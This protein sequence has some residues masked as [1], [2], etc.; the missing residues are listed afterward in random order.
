MQRRICFII[1]SVSKLSYHQTRNCT[2]LAA[3]WQYHSKKHLPLPGA[4]ALRANHISLR[5]KRISPNVSSI[6]AALIPGFDPDHSPPVSIC[7]IPFQFFLA[8]FQFKHFILFQFIKI[9]V[10]MPGIS[11]K[12]VGQYFFFPQL[13]KFLHQFLDVLFNFLFSF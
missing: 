5:K 13:L 8:D 4:D 6:Y 10:V 9:W 1:S 2:K 12:I 11:C 7:G 3:T